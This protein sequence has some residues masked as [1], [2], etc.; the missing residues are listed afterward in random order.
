M[1]TMCLQSMKKICSHLI[2]FH[3]SPMRWKQSYLN[4]ASGAMKFGHW[5]QMHTISSLVG[6]NYSLRVPTITVQTKAYCLQLS[7]KLFL[8]Y[9]FTLCRLA[10][11]KIYVSIANEVNH[12]NVLMVLVVGTGW[13]RAGL[14]TITQSSGPHPGYVPSSPQSHRSLHVS[15]SPIQC[16]VLPDWVLLCC[17]PYLSICLHKHLLQR[18]NFLVFCPHLH[19]THWMCIHFKTTAAL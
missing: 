3:V 16:C 9:A 4:L 5:T 7:V 17:V 1:R 18:G 11:N 8:V 2:R 6:Q 19:A 15:M 13:C 12:V 14:S 10:E